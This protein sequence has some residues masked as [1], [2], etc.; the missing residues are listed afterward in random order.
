MML[1]RSLLG[2]KQFRCTNAPAAVLSHTISPP[3]ARLCSSF[4]LLTSCVKTWPRS[5][6]KPCSGTGWG[7]IW[8]TES[9]STRGVLQAVDQA[10]QRPSRALAYA[11]T[12]PARPEAPTLPWRID[13]ESHRQRIAACASQ[14]QH[15]STHQPT[16]MP[17]PCTCSSVASSKSPNTGPGRVWEDLRKEV[18][19]LLLKLWSK[20]MVQRR[21]CAAACHT[22][23]LLTAAVP[24]FVC[25][26]AAVLWDCKDGQRAATSND[27]LLQRVVAAAV[28]KQL[29]RLWQP[30]AVHDYYRPVCCDSTPCYV[31]TLCW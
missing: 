28:T 22:H 27:D 6:Y 3:F 25:S 21:C 15:P 24:C 23:D 7:S 12:A 16:S 1:K 19:A 14:L 17:T 5:L 4:I 30:S 31:T 9:C 13:R 8:L 20:R 10:R 18:S 11:C 2:P 26:C 29:Q